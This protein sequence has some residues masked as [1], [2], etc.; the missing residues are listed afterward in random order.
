MNI[1]KFT[2][3]A[4]LYRTSRYYRMTATFDDAYGTMYPAFSITDFVK[5]SS[6]FLDLH[7][8]V[9][10][11]WVKTWA[12]C[13]NCLASFPCADESCRRQRLFSCTRKCD[14]ELTGGCDTKVWCPPGIA[15][16]N[17]VCCEPGEVCTLD[18]CSPPNRVCNDRICLGTCLPGGFCCPPDRIV[19][20]G[21]CCRPGKFC[22]R[23]GICC[24]DGTQC[25]GGGC[26]PHGTKCC[27]DKWCCPER[28]FCVSD[29][30]YIPSRTG[31]GLGHFRPLP[32]PGE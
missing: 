24:P 16:C 8:P 21:R 28:A 19:C 2:A 10:I 30:C 31:G 14:A 6:D 1:P 26:C 25:C 29:G 32:V 7:H 15:A 23:G 13:R 22:C 20:G 18:G 9:P 5:I 4:S 11:A 17:G 3:E 27:R 12:C